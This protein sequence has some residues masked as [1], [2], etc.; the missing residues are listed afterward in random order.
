MSICML[1][2]AVSGGRAAVGNRQWFGSSS[3][4]GQLL[5]RWHSYSAAPRE[6]WKGVYQNAGQVCAIEQLLSWAN[7]GLYQNDDPFCEIHSHFHSMLHSAAHICFT[8]VF[9][10]SMEDVQNEVYFLCNWMFPNFIKILKGTEVSTS[11]VYREY[12]TLCRQ[13]QYKNP[14]QYQFVI[15]LLVTCS[16]L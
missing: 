1:T 4:L 10:L 12:S 14:M 15:V 7:S 5:W 6:I 13:T 11:F 3:W 9:Y 2:E 16:R 8:D